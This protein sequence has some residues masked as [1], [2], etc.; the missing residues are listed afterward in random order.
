MISILEC[1][2]RDGSYAFDFQFS[3]DDTKTI[4]GALNQIGFEMI[5]VGH[6]IGLGASEKGKGYAAQTDAEYMQAAAQAVTKGQWGMFCIPGI[7]ELHHIAMA[8]DH[9]MGFIRIGTNIENIPSS[10]PFIEEAKKR[11][12]QVFT[13]FMKS[14]TIPPKEFAEQVKRSFDYGSDLVYLVDSAGGM[15]PSEVRQYLQATLDKIPNGR[16]GFHGHNNLGLGVANSIEAVLNGV[17]LV[18]ST[19]QGFGRSSGN[20]PTEQLLCALLRLNPD[21]FTIDPVKVL[22]ISRKYVFPLLTQRGHASLDVISGFALFHSSNMPMIQE[23]ATRYKV[24][25]HRLIIEVCKKNKLETPRSLVEDEAQRLAQLGMRGGGL[26]Y[27][28]YI[29]Q[30]QIIENI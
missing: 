9:G 25:P 30:E 2:L 14:Y 26:L 15:L 22:E 6:G 21:S 27:P 8:A 7:A 20:A 12:L 11:G 13:N 23:Y 18:D 19:L 28:P 29:G 24:D 16:L 10:K 17:E 3:S 4:A 1:T 5:E